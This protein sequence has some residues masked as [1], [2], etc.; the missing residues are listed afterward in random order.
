MKIIEGPK[1]SLE[2][3]DWDFNCFDVGLITADGRNFDEINGIDD[4]TGRFDDKGIADN[5]HCFVEIFSDILECIFWK[6][7]VRLIRIVLRAGEI[8]FL[9][10]VLGTKSI[11]GVGSD[12]GE[13]D[14]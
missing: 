9:N 8:I 14:L 3:E 11:I 7:L 5:T 13:T 6:C 12:E 1:L 10:N 2:R 4:Q